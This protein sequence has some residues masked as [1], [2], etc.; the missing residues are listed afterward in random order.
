MGIGKRSPSSGLSKRNSDKKLDPGLQFATIGK[1]GMDP[2]MQYAGFGKRMDPSLQ[3]A[4]FGKRMDP[5]LKYAGFGKRMDPSLQYAGFGKRMDPSLQFAGFGK[6]MDPS[7]QFAGFGKRMDPSLQYA[8]F[9]K[10]LDPSLQYAGFGKRLDPSLQFAGF[11]KKMDPSLKFAGF[12]KKM[13]PSLQ[14]AGFGKKMDPNYSVQ[15]V[16][17]DE[18]DEPGLNSGMKRMDPLLHFNRME[19]KWSGVTVPDLVTEEIGGYPV[20]AERARR[21]NEADSDAEHALL[22]KVIFK[23]LSSVKTHITPSRRYTTVSKKW[24]FDPP[25]KTRSSPRYNVDPTLALMG[26]GR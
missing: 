11:G 22:E 4:G 3:F 10:R 24:F 15:S 26:I 18:S 9:G 25:V 19:K 2:S 8:G 21:Q 1:R 20:T 6:R 17:E 12:G 23:L 5:S 16:V 14:F 7:L 13:D